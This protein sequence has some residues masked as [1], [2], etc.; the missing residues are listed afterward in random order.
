MATRKDINAVAQKLNI[1]VDGKTD[2]TAAQLI[3][4]YQTND[5]SRE[6]QK[7]FSQHH[8]T[9]AILQVIA[10][11]DNHTTVTH[12]PIDRGN[13]KKKNGKHLSRD[14]GSRMARR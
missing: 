13:G 1:M 10:T 14:R 12:N 11:S 5:R 2:A 7:L 3:L 6:I 9:V 4:D 8:L